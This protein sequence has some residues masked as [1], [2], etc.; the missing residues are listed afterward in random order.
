VTRVVVSTTSDEFARRVRLAGGA[1]SVQVLAGTPS[2]QRRAVDPDRAGGP[3]GDPTGLMVQLAAGDMPDVLVFGPGVPTDT[4]FAVA[5]VVDER[6][7]GTSVV[8]ATG[9]GPDEWLAAMRLG[10]RDVAAP[11]A[12]VADLRVVLER[13]AATAAARQRAASPTAGGRLRGR[14]IPVASPKGGC[15]K[16]TVAT[17]LAVGLARLAPQQ[18]VIL[19]LDLQFGD[20]ATALQLAPEQGLADA[21]RVKDLD[22]MALKTFLSPHPAGLYALCGPDSPARADAITGEDVGRLVDLLAGEFR[23]VVVD[24]APGLTEHTLA[25]L[26]QASDA[27][28]VAGM[29]VPSIRGLRKELEILREL[30]LTRMT[31]HVVVNFADRASGLTVKD[32][33]AVIGTAVDLVLPRS[34]AVPLSTNRGVPL[35]QSGGRDP[36]AKELQRL[37]ARFQPQLKKSAGRDPRHRA[38]TR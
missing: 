25:V 8:L 18:T 12:D 20:V 11:D 15:G 32:V 27:V 36:V 7:P 3:T 5:A 28:L 33:E 29:D 37:V 35:L 14:V 9:I 17:N 38:L 2:R 13:A 1:D 4:A 22:A 19:D 34:K 30:S 21:I 24:T 31:Q 6:H 16:T 23:Y 10:I 26:D